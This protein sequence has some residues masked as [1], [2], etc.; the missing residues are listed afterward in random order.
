MNANRAASSIRLGAYHTM[1]SQHWSSSQL[2]VSAVHWLLASL[3]TAVIKQ[4]VT[5]TLACIR[6]RF[7]HRFLSNSTDE[8]TK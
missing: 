3:Q 4:T 7:I 1:H 5:Q 6:Y 2:A 8:Q